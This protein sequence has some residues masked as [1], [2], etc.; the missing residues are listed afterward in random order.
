MFPIKSRSDPKYQ[1]KGPVDTRPL[2]HLASPSL[3]HVLITSNTVPTPVACM[4]MC[5]YPSP[6]SLPSKLSHYACTATS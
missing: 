2:S 5:M 6:P 1:C 4:C 3:V